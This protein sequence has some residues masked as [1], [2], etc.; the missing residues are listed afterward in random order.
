MPK[1]GQTKVK[2]GFYQ[3]K[4]RNKSRNANKKYFKQKE[5]S[6]FD[7]VNNNNHSTS[8]FSSSVNKCTSAETME[9]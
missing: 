8:N 3:S 4:R 9:Y 5:R 2:F 7:C 1:N 6:N